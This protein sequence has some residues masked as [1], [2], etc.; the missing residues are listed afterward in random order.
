MK[1]AR[2]I[3]EKKLPDRYK[4]WV[5]FNKIIKCMEEYADQFRQPN[6]SGSLAKSEPQ[7]SHGGLGSEWDTGIAGQMENY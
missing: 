3:L 6:V 1:T 4:K 7:E 2:E 5:D